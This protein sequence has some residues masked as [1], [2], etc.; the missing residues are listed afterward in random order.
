MTA[1]QLSTK[2]AKSK[3]NYNPV[4]RAFLILFFTVLGLLILIPLWAILLGSFKGG[5]ELFV[6][7]LNLRIEP[8]KLNL[9]SW[10]YLF[11]GIS[12]EGVYIAHDYFI[13]FKK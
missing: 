3:L 8:Q 11:T 12:R 10:K 9:L 2:K 4:A 6:S 13:W 1:V 7:G 5:S